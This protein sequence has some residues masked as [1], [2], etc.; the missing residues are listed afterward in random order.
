MDP[1]LQ[2]LDAS[3]SALHIYR[4]GEVIFFSKAKGIAPHLEAIEKIG[5]ESLRG[6]LMVDKVVGRAA[7]LLML[8]SLPAEVHAGV[9]THTAKSLLE[10]KGIKVVA[11]ETVD[12]VKQKDGR[13]Y[14]P[15]EAMVQDI[16]TPEEAYPAI[17]A[18]LKSLQNR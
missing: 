5:R 14:C 3:E 4:G 9:I 11:A 18:K 6:T 12:A 16:A 15:F 2:R 8:Y 17:V 10:E 13:I 1:Y 7:A